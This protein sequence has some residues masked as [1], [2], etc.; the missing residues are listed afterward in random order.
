MATATKN[1]TTDEILTIDEIKKRF[2]SEWVL[3]ADPELDED[4]NILS[5][6]VIWH[7]KDK[8]IFDDEMLKIEPFPKD[9]A[10]EYLGKH[11]GIY[12]L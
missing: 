6:K 9:V 5:G 4:F 2:D 7:H 1:A 8:L 3:V 10:V 11:E 12:V